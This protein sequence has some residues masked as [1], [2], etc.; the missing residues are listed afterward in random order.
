MAANLVGEVAAGVAFSLGSRACLTCCEVGTEMTLLAESETNFH[1][2]KADAT[3]RHTPS[4][5]LVHNHR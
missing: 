2:W 1:V 4:H 5:T 3:A